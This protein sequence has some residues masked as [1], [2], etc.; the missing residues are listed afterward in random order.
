MQGVWQGTAK[1]R[2]LMDGW[3]AWTDGGKAVYYAVAYGEEAA[4][5]YARDY[6]V[7]PSATIYVDSAAAPLEF[8]FTM[9]HR[10]RED[11]HQP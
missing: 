10:R 7:S 5:K 4:R 11:E 8:G 3:W 6:E 1:E 2:D 9:I